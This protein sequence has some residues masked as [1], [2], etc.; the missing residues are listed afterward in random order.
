MPTYPELARQFPTPDCGIKD[1]ELEDTDY[2]PLTM[3]IGLRDLAAHE[4]DPV[5]YRRL[6]LEL[7]PKP[8][9]DAIMA[10][11]MEKLSR[12]V[13]AYH[14][15]K[16]RIVGLGRKMPQTRPRPRVRH[17]FIAALDIVLNSPG[18]TPRQLAAKHIDISEGIFQ[19]ARAHLIEDGKVAPVSHQMQM[20][21]NAVKRLPEASNRQLAEI[22]GVSDK[23]IRR[24]RVKLQEG[25]I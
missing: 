10:L 7:P 14:S 12:L 1:R 6:R 2:H 23:T 16:T 4:I 24:A 21:I 19:E 20:A 13:D 8:N 11:M 17:K 9:H 3:D 22:A 15:R 25:K 18:V 5:K